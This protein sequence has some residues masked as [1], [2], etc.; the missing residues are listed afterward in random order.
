LNQGFKGDTQVGGVMG[1]YEES[2]G[3][4]L[5]MMSEIMAKAVKDEESLF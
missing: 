5:K 4:M 1:I 3:L 2:E